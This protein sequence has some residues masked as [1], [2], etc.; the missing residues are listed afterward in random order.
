MLIEA[1]ALQMDR[2]CFSVPLGMYFQRMFCKTAAQICIFLFSVCQDVICSD[3]FIPDN[4][5]KI[6]MCVLRQLMA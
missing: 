2:P 5:M 6:Q 4:R 3:G 1:D